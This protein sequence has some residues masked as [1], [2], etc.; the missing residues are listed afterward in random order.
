[1]KSNTSDNSNQSSIVLP[2]GEGTALQV[3]PGEHF[4]WKATGAT[5]AGALDLAQVTVEPQAGPPEHIHHQNDEAFYVL[6]GTFRFKV[7]DQMMMAPAGTFV[8][9]PRGT[10][11]TWQNAGDQPASLILLFTP[12]GMHGFFE[13]LEP[14]MVEPLDMDGIL[15]ASEKY[16]V[17]TIGPPLG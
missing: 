11:H 6:D 8:F 16:R 17:E 9:V 2:P 1:M 14:L 15:V 10:A 3:G 13:E 4:V 12:G 5:T 7:G